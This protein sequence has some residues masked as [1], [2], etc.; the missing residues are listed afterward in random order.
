MEDLSDPIKKRTRASSS[1]RKGGA[2]SG[3]ISLATG[4]QDLEQKKVGDSTRALKRSRKEAG[5]G[6]EKDDMEVTNPRLLSGRW[7]PC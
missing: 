2:R 5:R 4:N 3:A 7:G 6:T 1:C